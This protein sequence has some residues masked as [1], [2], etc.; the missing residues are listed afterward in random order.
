MINVSTVKPWDQLVYGCFEYRGSSYSISMPRGEI[1]V[2]P[3]QALINVCDFFFFYI[4]YFII[5]FCLY[6]LIITYNKRVSFSKVFSSSNII[7]VILKIQTFLQ[8]FLQNVD[9]MSGKW[10][11]D[12][13]GG[14]SE[15]Q[16]E[17]EYINNL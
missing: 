15:N 17:I 3:Q 4:Y 9:V 7:R 10:K 12:I 5:L 2:N 13:N 14:L 8:K 11:S 16:Y 6:N 1:L